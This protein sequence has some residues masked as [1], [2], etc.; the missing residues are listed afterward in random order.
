M[1]IVLEILTADF[2]RKHPGMHVGSK[3]FRDVSYWIQGIEFCCQY[4][5]PEKSFDLN[6]FREWLLMHIGGP[7]NMDWARLI[8]MAYGGGE[9]ATE[10]AFELLDQF[11]IDRDENGLDKIIAD[12][13]EYEMKRYGHLASSRLGEN[14]LEWERAFGSALI[15]GP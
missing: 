14:G 12:H 4:K 7:S 15:I 5:L 9:D 2:F 13:A 6:G 1:G 10:K 8:E 11:L 3:E